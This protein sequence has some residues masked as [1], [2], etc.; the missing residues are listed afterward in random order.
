MIEKI[1]KDLL[2]RITKLDKFS[3]YELDDYIHSLIGRR[4]TYIQRPSKC[5]QPHC[6]KCRVEGI[7]HG[8]YWFAKFR[9]EGRQHMVYIGKAKREINIM[10]VMKKKKEKKQKSKK[11][12]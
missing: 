10:E 8:L 1:G 9:H 6:K 3:L 4:V 5:G 2:D 11:R 7:G 12:G